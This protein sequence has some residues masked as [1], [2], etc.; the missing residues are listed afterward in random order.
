MKRINEADAEG[1]RYI[2]SENPDGSVYEAAA[3]AID[4]ALNPVFFID[5]DGARHYFEAAEAAE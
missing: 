2:G 1:L 5:K 4:H 3:D